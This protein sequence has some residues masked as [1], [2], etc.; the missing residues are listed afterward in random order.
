MQEPVRVFVGYDQRQPIAYHVLAHS[1]MRRSSVPV[2]IT[3]LILSQLPMTRR[4]LTEFTFSR[5]LVPYLAGH[6]GT[7]IFLDSDMLVLGD[8]VELAAYGAPG[9]PAVSVHPYS[10]SMAFERPAV[11]V[12]NCNHDA[13]QKITPA[14]VEDTSN[15]LFDLAW[16][17]GSIGVLPSTWTRLVGYEEVTPDDR[18]LHYTQGV[19]IWPE[20]A[21]GDAAQVYRDEISHMSTVQSWG[22]ILGQSV[23]APHVMQR[24]QEQRAASAA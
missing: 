20:T 24:L 14:F 1:I 5:F 16:A 19:P 11:M 6:R 9:R 21:G 12:F 23:H 22:T 13:L 2:A 17:D 7:A 18:L 4:G 3:P 8:I 15:K 10:G